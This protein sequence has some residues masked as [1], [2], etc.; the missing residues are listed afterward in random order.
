VLPFLPANPGIAVSK[1]RHRRSEVVEKPTFSGHRLHR[2]WQMD[3]DRSDYGIQ[4]AAI[5]P[6]FSC[7]WQGYQ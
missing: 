5:C 3:A 1:V 4:L 6:F 2:N 7:T